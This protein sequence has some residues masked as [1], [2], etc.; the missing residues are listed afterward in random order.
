MA[1][2]KRLGGKKVPIPDRKI[3]DRIWKYKLSDMTEAVARYRL[4]CCLQPRRKH[5]F[6]DAGLIHT[7]TRTPDLVMDKLLSEAEDLIE[8]AILIDPRLAKKVGWRLTDEGVD[9]CPAL[10]AS[11]EERC[12]FQRHRQRLAEAA[13]AEPV[14][15]VISTDS[16]KVNVRNAVAFI[17]AAKLAQQFRPLELWWQGAWLMDEGCS[18]PEERGFGHVFHVPLI[19][20]DMD[21]SRLVF[22]LS[23]EYRDHVSF[24]IMFS[25]AY[26]AHYGWGGG[27]G[28]SSMLEGTHDFV[29]ETG[30]VADPRHVAEYAAKWAG[31]DPLWE[32][33][34]SEYEA[35]QWWRPQSKG[36]CT[37]VKETAEQRRERLKRWREADERER[38][39]R[40]EEANDRLVNA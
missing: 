40:K 6:M 31:M 14:R 9:G 10:I 11:G 23:S 20:G 2:E 7:I 34:V 19:Q 35:Q 24:R 33:R 8:E 36:P 13:T 4:G 30:I 37:P 12:Y 26:P 21:F 3:L 32:I 28:G 39:R 18:H 27:V 38:Q 22:V 29:R 15:V 16:K 5:H 1:Q 17:A 25:Y